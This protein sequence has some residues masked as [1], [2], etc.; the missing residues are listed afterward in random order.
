[1]Q[2]YLS[3][4]RDNGPRMARPDTTLAAATEYNS[5]AP[6]LTCG[7]GG[8]ERLASQQSRKHSANGSR[9]RQPQIATQH[10]SIDNNQPVS[11]CNQNPQNPPQIAPCAF[12]PAECRS[13]HTQKSEGANQRPEELSVP[14]S[15]PCFTLCFFLSFCSEKQALPCVRIAGKA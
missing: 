3:S 15:R 5:H 4:H 9:H 1:M 14:L 12:P 2:A 8:Q 7:I 6:N 13:Y 11:T 10:T